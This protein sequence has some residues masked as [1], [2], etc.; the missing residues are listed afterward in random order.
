MHM[1]S[2]VYN[3]NKGVDFLSQ[4][5]SKAVQSDV[6]NYFIIFFFVSLFEA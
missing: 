2:K 5:A 1:R 6:A 3:A 4:K